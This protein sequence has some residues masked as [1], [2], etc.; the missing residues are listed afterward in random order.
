[1]ILPDK[2][3]R[4]LVADGA[5]E[6]CE[7]WQIQPASIDLTLGNEFRTMRH[8]NHLAVNLAEAIPS[9][10]TESVI[11]DRFVLHA[12]ERVLGV[13]RELLTIPNGMVGRMEGKSSLGRLFLIV[14]V[15]AGFF[16]PGFSGRGTLEFVNLSGAP[17]VFEPERMREQQRAICQFSF[18]TM[19]GD[20]EQVYRG[21]YQ[22][23]QTVA[24]S[25]YGAILTS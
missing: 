19:T 2:D 18:M 16:D 24:P 5:V 20:S 7:D 21:R 13:T 23:D 25:R 6:P 3:L 1:M 4:A 14:H 22:N 9:D 11:T 12:G 15:T 17:I 10:L 8:H